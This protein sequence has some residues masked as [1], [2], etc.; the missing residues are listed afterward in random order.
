MLFVKQLT[1]FDKHFC[2]K[3]SSQNECSSGYKQTW[4][5]LKGTGKLQC[6]FYF[7]KVYV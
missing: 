2:D 6:S 4:G 5:G 1:Q 3:S 7:Y